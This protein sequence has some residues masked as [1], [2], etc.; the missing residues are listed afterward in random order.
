MGQRIINR[1]RPLR[2]GELRSR[3]RRLKHAELPGERLLHADE[4]FEYAEYDWYDYEYWEQYLRPARLNALWHMLG[5][6]I[7]ASK[8][9]NPALPLRLG[10]SAELTTPALD[11][12]AAEVDAEGC[13]PAEV[14]AEGCSPLDLERTLATYYAQLPELRFAELP[15][16]RDDRID[17][18]RLAQ[19]AAEHLG[20]QVDPLVPIVLLRPFWSRPPRSWVWSGSAHEV[21]PSLVEHVFVRFPIPRFLLNAWV[22]P[23]TVISMR[24]LLWT[25]A[26]G[27]GGSLRRL[28]RLVREGPHHEDWGAIA[29]KLPA[30]L[31]DVPEGCSPADGVMFAEILRL[32]GSAVEFRRLV[33]DAS[34]RL[35]PTSREA[36]DDERVFWEQTVRWLVR[37]RDA[38]DDEGC[39]LCLRWARHRYTERHHEPFDWRGRTPASA[40]REAREYMR[41]LHGSGRRKRRWKPRGWDWHGRV[42]ELGWSVHELVTSDELLDES[43]A[44]S[45]C[46]RTYDSRCTQGR[47]AIFSLR[48]GERRCLT[49][50]VNPSCRRVVQAR[51]VCNR[52][53]SEQET[54]VLDHWQRQVL[55]AESSSG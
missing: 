47:S 23:S 28:N 11:G 12:A 6:A 38:L 29:K 32:G 33:E 50:E 42:A 18:Q 39:H 14:D 15:L 20:G 49:V 4:E 52:S 13:S 48:R 10:Q 37:H 40:I 5:R 21:I 54:S 44:M 17:L 8:P 27:Q 1:H 30:H 35:D 31:G 16:G 41:Q 34:Y 3:Y 19:V 53:A 26:L 9:F 22:E 51:G 55:W 24:W 46:V 45:H 7:V 25:V 2:P 43:I 36:D